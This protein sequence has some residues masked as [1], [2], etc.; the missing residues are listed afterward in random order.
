MNKIE[1]DI[2]ENKAFLQ[3]N[4][5]DREAI[6]KYCSECPSAAELYS[7]ETKRSAGKEGGE[8]MQAMN[9]FFSFFVPNARNWK[10]MHKRSFIDDLFFQAASHPERTA[11]VDENRTRFTTY[12]EFTSLIRKTAGKL[13]GM[14]L[15]PGSFIVINMGRCRE[16]LTAFYAVIYAGYAV[17]PL[18]PEIPA[19]RERYII[20]E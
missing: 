16:Y 9:R 12:A 19:E 20:D 15:T 17:I 11:V 13:R 10:R 8:Y 7:R 18:V 6:L 1:K 14:H 4:E 3:L 5:E 2:R